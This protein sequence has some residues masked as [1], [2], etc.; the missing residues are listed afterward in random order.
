M[1]HY[2]EKKNSYFINYLLHEQSICRK[3][4]K[5]KTRAFSKF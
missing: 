2:L 5:K 1:A 4:K 3:K